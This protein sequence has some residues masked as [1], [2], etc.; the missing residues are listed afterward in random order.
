VRPPKIPQKPQSVP[1]KKIFAHWNIEKR[2]HGTLHFG[3]TE[4]PGTDNKVNT[5]EA[6]TKSAMRTGHD[7]RPEIVLMFMDQ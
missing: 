3:G 6:P 2:T 4:M 7:L 5:L 1:P